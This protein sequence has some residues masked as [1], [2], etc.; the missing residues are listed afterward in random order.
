M[1][2]RFEETINRM[3]E[4]K[5]ICETIDPDLFGYLSNQNH[6]DEVDNFLHKI[7]RQTAR[8]NDSRGFYCVFSKL[9]TKSKRSIAQRQFDNVTVNLEGLIGW[10]RLVRNIDSD[11]RPIDAGT[12]LN[13]S[14][15]LAAIEESSS[16][17]TQLENIAHKFK[18]SGKSSET[19]IKLLNVMQYLTEQQYL[20]PIGSSGS[21]YIATAKWSLLYDQM[22][23]IRS[24]EGYSDELNEQESDSDSQKDMFNG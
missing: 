13:E 1:D 3:L 14:E 4:Q 8:T 17:S 22:E 6:R 11:S 19:K 23:F 10:L 18:K 9:D 7:G 5:V 21:V 12:R 15:L 16:L 20:H 2:N 24:H